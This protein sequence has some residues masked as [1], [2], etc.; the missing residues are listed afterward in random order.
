MQNT[1]KKLAFVISFVMLAAAYQNCSMNGFGVLTKSTP[2]ASSGQVVDP[3]PTDG[4][5]GK[6]VPVFVAQGHVGR[7]L[8]SCDDGKSWIHDINDNP[9]IVCYNPDECDHASFSAAGLVY[10]D[11]W[12]FAS[13]GHGAPGTLRR[14]KDGIK[15]E[16][17]NT[18]N[19]TGGLN[20]VN[21]I[22]LWFDCGYGISTD[23]GV[24]FRDNR[25]NVPGA[26]FLARTAA[27]A[28]NVVVVSGD[29]GSAALLSQDSGLTWKAI[30]PQGVQW[31]RNNILAKGNGI[32]AS[33]SS[34]H[35]GNGTGGFNTSVYT[36]ISTDG[37]LTWNGKALYEGP[38]YVDW[39][40]MFFDGTKFI[41]YYGNMRATSVDGV[42]WTSVPITTPGYIT[43]GPIARGPTGTLVVIPNNFGSY[44][45]KQRAYRSTDGMNWTELDSTQ[46]HG[47]HPIG[48]I[49][50]GYVD[51]S[52]CR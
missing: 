47:G 21:G 10:N 9:K 1:V 35:Y 52:A 13:Y 32:I 24:T 15:W 50:S 33:A 45:D 31:G 19:G 48:R 39:S 51:S 17:I 6:L 14:S 43:N 28:G 22:L 3:A 26:Y 40:A 36:S 16:V 5:T 46:F 2:A 27:S 20:F 42:N 12:F 18:C 41:G 8:M 44:Y 25:Q 4:P 37:G 38:N 30:S 7:T 23:L 11:G 29:D 49:V 34:V